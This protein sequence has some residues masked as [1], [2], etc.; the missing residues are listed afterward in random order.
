MKRVGLLLLTLI[1][2]VT[3][4]KAQEF[5][6]DKFNAMTLN[7]ITMEDLFQENVSWTFF[8]SK[9]GT[10]TSEPSVNHEGEYTLKHFYYTGAHFNFNNYLG[11]YDFN[12]AVITSSNYVFTYD[13]LQIKVGNALS[14]VS[15]RF[16]QAYANRKDGEMYIHHAL[17]GIVMTLYY[18]N[19]GM[20]TKVEL[21]QFLI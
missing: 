8:K 20:I 1:I 14:T 9:M 19:N 12:E 16:P 18:D 21:F 10:P 13:G 15:S 11:Q 17:G 4:A 2:I 5:A 7:S 6:T 3:V